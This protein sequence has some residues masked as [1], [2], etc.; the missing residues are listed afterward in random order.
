[1]EPLILAQVLQLGGQS[2][3]CADI[4][5]PDTFTDCIL[6]TLA[7][8]SLLFGVVEIEYICKGIMLC[9]L[10]LFFQHTSRIRHCDVKTM[11]VLT[12]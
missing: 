10:I 7:P 2:L 1:M 4:L 6:S 11:H 5:V 3:S 8:S 12:E 9:A